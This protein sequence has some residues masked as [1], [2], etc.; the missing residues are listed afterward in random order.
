[1][2]LVYGGKFSTVDEMVRENLSALWDRGRRFPERRLEREDIF[3]DVRARFCTCPRYVGLN[4]ACS[5]YR[6]IFVNNYAF[7]PGV[8]HQLKLRFQHLK[9][10]ARIVSSKAF[11]P[12]NFRITDRNLTGESLTVS[13]FQG[14]HLTY[15]L[16]VTFSHR[17]YAVR[18]CA[19][20]HSYWSLCL[21]SSLCLMKL[22]DRA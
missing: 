1:M 18:V 12:V 9:E 22:Y 15:L 21:H 20:A 7:G 8:D 19:W 10:G 16:F 14:V 11:A 13:S 17:F 6:V 5:C 3:R 4:A 2:L